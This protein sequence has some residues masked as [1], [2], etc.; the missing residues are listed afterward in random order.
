MQAS[1][2]MASIPQA[3]GAGDECCQQI[4]PRRCNKVCTVHTS[5]HMT[6]THSLSD[7]L[8]N[9]QSTRPRSQNT[10]AATDNDGTGSTH[11]RSACHNG[12]PHSY[13]TNI[14]C[15]QISAPRQAAC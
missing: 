8:S 14:T 7:T 13:S 10:Q 1:A 15:R 5:Q 2:C 3:V 4:K 11:D 6:H 12:Q 9:P